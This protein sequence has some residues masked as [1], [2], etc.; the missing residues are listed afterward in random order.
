M[1]AR[2]SRRTPPPVAATITSAPLSDAFESLSSQKILLFGG[3]GG[4]GKTTLATA[5]ALWFAQT[6]RV[7]LFTTDPAS[8]LSDLLPDAVP[9]ANLTIEAIDGDALYAR[10]LEQHLEGFLELGDRGTYLERDELQRFFE[11]SMPGVDELMAWS[12]IGELAEESDDLLIVDTAPTGHTLRMLSSGEHFHQFA[13]ALDSLQAKHRGMM[14]QFLR[15]DVRDAMDQF[16]EDFASQAS[17]RRERLADPSVTAFIP[18]TL[19]E[20]WVVEQTLR[21]IDEVRRDG[22]AVPLGILNRAIALPDCDTDR[23]RSSR[24]ADARRELAPLPIVDAPRACTPLDDAE[25]IRN[26]TRNALSSGSATEPPTASAP[27]F[28][29]AAIDLGDARLLFLAGKG[30]VGKTT[31]S[32]SIALQL[33]ERF[34]DRQFTVLSVDP[35]HSLRVVFASEPPP[36][37]L[38]VEAI[39]TR[40]RWLHFRDSLGDEIERAVGALTPGNFSVAYDTEAIRRLIEIAPPGADEIFAITR[41][42]DLLAD[43]S[44]KVIVV[45]TAPTG[46]FLRLLDLPSTAGEWVREFMRILLRYRELMPAGALGEELVRASRALHALE[47]TLRSSEASVV[48]VTRPERMV[49]AETQRLLADL[50]RRGIAVTGVIA[51]YVTPENDCACDRSV[52]N[53]EVEALRALD[54]E[55]VVAIARREEP[56]VRLE[57]LK[58]LVP[59]AG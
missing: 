26:W 22:L 4:V 38:H 9:I 12:R 45:D 10:F 56:L 23:R 27:T 51:N 28:V 37:N 43:P 46:H 40:E 15:R 25:R 42:S 2:K 48:V 34:P 29:R 18:V 32:A 1:S 50:A 14:R 41:L 7:K 55:G 8:N 24:D 6:R 58:A 49:I 35:A 47:Q 59:L 39:D 44:Q 13:E 33:A 19:S 20:P 3:K 30:G 53:A 11:L 31:S 54:H 52:R 16:L 57:D 21:L 5:A 17:G 36:Q